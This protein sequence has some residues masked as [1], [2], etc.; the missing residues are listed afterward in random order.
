[1][2]RLCAPR[3]RH[4]ACPPSGSAV[5]HDFFVTE[6]GGERVAIELARLLPSARVYTSFF[7]AGRFGDRITPSRV[8]TWPLQRPLGATPHFRALYPLYP[9]YF[10]TLRIPSR[11]VIS[12]SVAFSKAVRTPA[13]SLHVSYVHTP[14]RYAWELESYL[15]GSSLP[16]IARAAA[17]TIR[18]ILQAWDRR[19][20]GRPDLIVTNSE[21]V[22]FRIQA[23]W[24]RDALVIHPPIETAAIPLSR[25]DDGYLLIAA[26]LLAYRRVDL[27]VQAATLLGRRLVVIGDGPERH[28]LETLA[29]PLVEFRGHVA[30]EELIDAFARCH[31]Y[32]VPGVEDFGMAPVEAMAAGKPVVALRAGGATETV[33]EGITGVFFD[34]PTPTALADGIERLDRSSLSPDAI[35][36]HALGFDAAVFRRRWRELLRGEGV[37]PSL[38]SAG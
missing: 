2:S 6:G 12:S 32:L 18:P 11:L 23:L 19:T 16:G 17:R 26:R 30:R 14:L 5:V 8:H 27:A 35:R 25:R 28:R 3:R 29:G 24:D 1:M 22:R 10:A 4:R 13:G 33:I 34:D 7:D 15:A 31:A 9:P 36:T 21:T 20:A 37:D 38:Y